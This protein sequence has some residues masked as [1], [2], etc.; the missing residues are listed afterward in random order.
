MSSALIIGGGIGGLTA[1][2]ALHRKGWDVA[3]Y[4]AAP[5]LRPVGKGI[6]VP[7]NA[8]QVLERLDLAAAVHDAGWALDVIQIRTL[9]GW[10]LSAVDLQAVQAKY[11]HTTV[12]IQRATLVDAL[13]GALPAGTLHLNKR[14]TGF[15]HESDQVVAHFADGTEAV[16]TL[17]IGADGIR[18]AVREQLFPGVPLR[19][20]GQ[21]CYR[22]V[23][24]MALPHKLARTCWEV[25]GG[26]YRFGFSAVGPQQVYWFA[27]VTAPAGKGHEGRLVAAQLAQWYAAF[28]SPIPEIIA[29]TD[30]DDIIQTDL[31]DFSPMA[32]WHE[33][34]VVLLGDAAHAMTPNLGQGGAQAIEDAWVLA[35]TLSGSSAVAEAL[36][37]YERMRMPKAAWLTKNSRRMGQ[38]AHLEQPV[39]R[40]VRDVGLRLTPARVSQK[41]MDRMYGLD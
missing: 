25:W 13:H 30:S 23:A 3:V 20:S 36:T 41:Q 18:S 32:R 26:R 8:M 19:Y 33:G 16:G 22:G 4:E 5:A 31:Y 39:A 35:E 34:R 11:G 2:V 12:S 21:T 6:W 40:W 9:S 15:T 37:H 29:A 7:T 17:L 38:A 28:P 1:A 27:P 24:D 14:F 10:V